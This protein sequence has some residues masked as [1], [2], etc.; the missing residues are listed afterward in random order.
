MVVSS[1]I[2]Y[3]IG[4]NFAYSLA[5]FIFVQSIFYNGDVLISLDL[6]TSLLVSIDEIAFYDKKR[7]LIQK[8][9]LE[10]I[11][12]FLIFAVN[13]RNKIDKI[14]RK[15]IF[16]YFIIT[17][18]VIIFTALIYNMFGVNTF[19]N[20][21][22]FQ[23]F[24]LVCTRTCSYF[25]FF[26]I[27]K[28]FNYKEYRVLKGVFIILISVLC[29]GQFFSELMYFV[30]SYILI[31]DIIMIYVLN[32]L[33]ICIFM[34]I[35]LIIKIDKIKIE[36]ETL[37][38]LSIVNDKNVEYAN[39]LS[40]QLFEM[41][42]IRHNHQNDFT[43]LLHLIEN[44]EYEKAEQY[45]EKNLENVNN[46]NKFVSS[47]N[48]VFDALINQKIVQYP[49]IK[50]KCNFS[51]LNQFKIDNVDFCCLL[52]NI[53]NNAFEAA[54]SY[55]E[56][57][58]LQGMVNLEVKSSDKFMM[59]KVNNS[60]NNIVDINNLK[61]NKINESLHGYG[62]KHIEQIVKKYKGIENRK[63]KDSVFNISIVLQQ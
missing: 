19:L 63:I 35:I 53:L 58:N 26:Y 36:N 62:I 6:D 32:L 8:M 59:I 25:S 12:S 54:Q 4:V 9:L 44:N 60:T 17:I 20:L 29:L 16:S 43:V 55:V 3:F 34:V 23:T 51:K 18:V 30:Y 57:N 2:Y 41:K 47:G 11:Q 42:T 33:I 39:N 28:C 31:N 56:N 49:H 40:D 27:M 46:L 22:L 14:G 13:V 61:S 10:V 15:K 5:F 37:Q 50:F 45:I 24:L 48:F 1:E 38:Y 21:G 52:G 7:N